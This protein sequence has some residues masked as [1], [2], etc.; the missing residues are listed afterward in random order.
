MRKLFFALAF[1]ISLSAEAKLKI[2]TTT[3]DLAALV[4]EVGGDRVD[5]K[6][7]AKGTQDAHQIEAKPSLMVIMRDADLVVAQ[8]LELESAWLGPLIQGS[9][10]PKIALGSAGYLSLG[11]N[12]NPI[13]VR[14][15]GASR[16][17]GDVHPGGNPHFQL[18]PIRLG[19]A[20]ELIA[21]KLSA[22][23]DAGAFDYGSHAKA[24]DVKMQEK[25]K[26]WTA[27]IKAAKVAEIVT[28]HKTFSYF[29]ERFQIR[30]EMQ[31][32]PRPGIPPTVSHLLEVTSYLKDKKIPL[33]LVENYFDMDSAAK[34]KSEVPGLKVVAVPVS[35]EGESNIKTSEQLIERLVSE[36][37]KARK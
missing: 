30:C 11:E 19:K 28:H 37:E 16:A 36:I 27:R 17:E 7:L 4:R 35:V 24:F 25:T 31:L 9:R 32:E 21:V 15:A 3:T 23:D 34:L 6:A 18:D 1:L 26:S 8:G 20:A 5:V 12:L 22:M 2:V 10:N 29:C 13:E 33:V 14:G